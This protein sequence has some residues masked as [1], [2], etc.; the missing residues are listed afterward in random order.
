LKAKDNT[1]YGLVNNA[2]YVEPGA[3]DDI[4]INDL[5]NQFETNRSLDDFR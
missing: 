5:R 2:G 3:V 4:T 1:I